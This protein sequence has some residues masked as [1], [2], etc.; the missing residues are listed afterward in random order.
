MLVVEMWNFFE[1]CVSNLSSFLFP[2]KLHLGLLGTWPKRDMLSL[3]FSLS[4]SRD[5]GAPIILLFLPFI[6][7]L[8]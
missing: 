7:Q 6:L 2:F 3:Y 1:Q 4:L 8:G 5:S